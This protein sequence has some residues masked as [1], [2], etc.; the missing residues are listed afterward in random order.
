MYL[1]NGRRTSLSQQRVIRMR[2]GHGAR[3]NHISF[4]P[5]GRRIVTSSHDATVRLWDVDERNLLWTFHGQSDSRV[6]DREGTLIADA[7][8]SASFSPNG[9]HVAVGTGER[10]VVILDSTTGQ[11]VARL[12][13]HTGAVTCVAFEPSGHRLVSGAV[14]GTIRVW[15]LDYGQ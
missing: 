12:Y 7:L 1:G 8:E 14:D 11:E 10:A 4:S 15:T 9:K 13:G 6:V 5:D 2:E 3:I